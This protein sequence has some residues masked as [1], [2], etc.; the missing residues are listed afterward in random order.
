MKRAGQTLFFLVCVL[1]TVLAVY[2]VQSDNA[3]VLVLAS[4]SAC[5]GEPATC[6][7]QMTRMERTPFGQTFELATSKHK[8]E[9]RCVRALVLIGDY[10]CTP[11]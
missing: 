7:A 8:V 5:H 1:F 4:E 3:G 2:N 6:R 9:V 11:R 10:S